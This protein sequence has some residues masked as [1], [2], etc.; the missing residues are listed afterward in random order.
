[1]AIAPNQHNCLTSHIFPKH[2]HS[3]HMRKSALRH[4]TLALHPNRPALGGPLHWRAAWVCLLLLALLSPARVLG[5][6][7]YFTTGNEWIDYSQTYIKLLVNQDGIYRLSASDPALQA[8]GIDQATPGNLHLYYR[9]QEVPI[10]VVNTGDLNRFEGQDFIEFFGRRNDG[11][12]DA[13]MFRNNQNNLFNVRPDHATNT[14]FSLFTD[15]SAY[16]LTW[17]A[18]PGLRLVNSTDANFN[19]PER[20]FYRHT[21]QIQFFPGENSFVSDYTAGGGG[22]YDPYNNTNTNYVCGEGYLSPVFSGPQT[23]TLST[24]HKLGSAF[25]AAELTFRMF[26]VSFVTHRVQVSFGTRQ[27]QVTLVNVDIGNFQV[28]GTNN[29]L[30]NTNTPVT[31]TPQGA[32]AST[33]DNVRLAWV[34]LKYDRQFIFDNAATARISLPNDNQRANIRLQGLNI[35]G[36]DSV[37]I[38]DLTNSVRIRATL[39]GTDA[40]AIIPKGNGNELDIWV[41]N[42]SSVRTPLAVMPVTFANLASTV[43]GAEMLVITNR[44]FANSAQRYATYRDTCSVNSLTTRVVYVDQIFDEFG[45]GSVTPLAIKNFCRATLQRWNPRLQYILLWGKG[46]YEYRGQTRNF[47]PTWNDPATDQEFVSNFDTAWAP[48]PLIP[49]GRLNILTDQAGHDYIDKLDEYEHTPYQPWMKNAVHLG[50]GKTATEQKAIYDYLER[51]EILYEGCP[52]DGEVYTHQKTSSSIVDD[53]IGEEVKDAISRGGTM[54]TFFG[55]STSNIFDVEILEPYYYTNYGKYPFIIALGCYPGNFATS[56]IS[57]GERFMAEKNRGSIGYLAATSNGY[58]IPMGPFT[59]KFYQ[60]A[61]RDSLGLPVGRIYRETCAWHLVAAPG[62]GV[63]NNCR[64]TNIQ[65]DPSIALYHARAT[66]LAIAV[67]DVYFE[68]TDFSAQSDS[69]TVCVIA[70]NLGKCFAVQD[71]F[72]LQ[73]RQTVASSATLLDHGSLRFPAFKSIDTLKFT[74]QRNGLDISGINQFDIF[75]DSRNEHPELREDNNRIVVEKY[76]PSNRPAIIYPWPFAVINQSQIELVASTF[77]VN[78][79]T[80][81][82]YVFEVDTTHLFNSGMWRTSNNVIG[83]AVEGRWAMPYTLTDST[84]YYWR[85]RLADEPGD[86]WATASFQYIQ[87]PVEGWA[88]ARPAQFFEDPTTGIEM[89]QAQ[90]QWQFSPSRKILTM[91]DV[92]DYAF[93]IITPNSGEVGSAS[94]QIAGSGLSGIFYTVVD[95]TTLAPETYNQDLGYCDV[96]VPQSILNLV[97][98]IAN[99]DCGDYIGIMS[100]R[101]HQIQSWPQAVFDALNQVGVG[102]AIRQLTNGEQFMLVGRKCSPIGSADEFLKPNTP[103]GRFDIR[104]DLYGYGTTGTITS[105][106]IG[107]ALEW[108]DLIWDWKKLETTFGDQAAVTLYGVQPNGQETPLISNVDKGTYDLRSFTAT[109]YPFMRLRAVVKDSITR[110][111]PQL[112]NWYVLYAPVPEAIL[113]PTI[114]Y[115]FEFDTVNEGQSLR[116]GLHVRNITSLGMDSLLVRYNVR[117]QAGAQLVLDT[118]RIAPLPGNTGLDFS[119]TFNSLQ[120]NFDMS[121][122]N[123]LTVFVNPEFDQPERFLFNNVY[124]RP[125]YVIKDL[126][127]P[128]LDVTFDGKRILNNDIVSPQPTIVIQLNDENQFFPLTDTTNI[129][130]YFKKANDPAPAQRV[131]YNTATPKLEFIPAT[132]PNNKAQ[133]IYRPDRLEDGTYVL[134]VQGRDMNRN[135]S[136]KIPYEV[137]FRVINESSIT[138]VVNY[139]NPFTTSTRFVYTLT[140]DQLPDRFEIHIYTISGRLVKVIDLKALG[141]AFIGT[142]ITNYA[143]DGTDDYG[144][145]LANGVYLYKVVLKM[146]GDNKIKLDDSATEK[147]FTNGWGKMVLMR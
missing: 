130:V 87:G 18:Q 38:Y 73:I 44:A 75:I 144:D 53:N 58:L 83:T 89:R 13:L 93:R 81:V 136:G 85:V 117:N 100:V 137:N 23:F 11:E 24:P 14:H 9:G 120:P 103:D 43:I 129:E 16:F 6:I 147:Y 37:L 25:N 35:P 98:V 131:F 50:G 26:G 1:M 138:Q 69:F 12:L 5:Q 40:R 101:S 84:V 39:A 63:Y 107:P 27:Q 54:I 88:Q 8:T 31:F 79:N 70:R 3:S 78:R 68:P 47:V 104:K 115:T 36:G 20:Q 125:F 77:S 76:I 121:G 112:D 122:L 41:S 105:P 132:L 108:Y 2:P 65:G 118:V 80:N 109:D 96:I 30:G 17:N 48:T 90:R 22:S 56:Q 111:A 32:V 145:A 113:D 141:D 57:F 19:I 116:V 82:K 21:A 52:Q 45:Y 7:T 142:H 74:I 51:F 4:T 33:P 146:P 110:T 28:N 10:H 114:N 46:M 143:W 95:G 139:P 67:E 34:K 128:I 60:V 72:S 140:G 106:L 126:I 124:T 134:Q 49:I 123:T 66:D 71:S 59:E 42:G 92:V 99:M 29:D 97:N 119:Y 91:T 64:Q 102:N 94:L 133:V 15:T 135:A 55:H 61:F 62:I 127:N 86:Q